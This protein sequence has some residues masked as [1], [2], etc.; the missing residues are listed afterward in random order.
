MRRAV[1]AACCLALTGVPAAA[2]AAEP[3][4]ETVVA[5]AAFPTNLAFGPSGS[6]YF[7]EKDTGAIREVTGDGELLPDPVT[8]FEVTSEGET[9]ALGIAS[10]EDWLYVYLSDAQTGTNRIVRFPTDDPE[11]VEEVADLLPTTAGYHNGGDLAIGP[12]GMVYATVGEMHEPDRAQDPADLGGKIIRLAP[13]GAVPRDNPFGEDNPAWSM[14]HRNSFGICFDLE[15]GTLYETENGPDSHDEVNVIERG[16]NYG[17]PDV[18]GPGGEPDFIDPLVD[19]P[20]IVAPTGCSVWGHTLWFGDF[21]GNLYRLSLPAEAPASPEIVAQLPGG[22][23]DVARGPGDALYIAT[24]SGIY[25]LAMAPPA[26]QTASAAPSPIPSPEPTGERSLSWPAV[27]AS[28]LA[29]ALVV[30]GGLWFAVIRRREEAEGDAEEA[31]EA[32]GTSS[33]DA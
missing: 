9:G 33:P 20:E 2:N 3:E 27:I 26:G 22:I 4:V 17:W 32:E 15:T 23:T 13:D 21:G 6:M 24:Q 10:Y 8:T 30:A 31:A 11:A 28:V 5:G 12:D 14:G 7:T 16:G 25:R 18:M 1:I 19:F 29:L